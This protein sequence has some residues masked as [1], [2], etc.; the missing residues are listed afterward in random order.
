MLDLTETAR[1]IV[2]DITTSPDAPARAGLRISAEPGEGVFAVT[3]ADEPDP[4]DLVVRRDGATVYLD[5]ATAAAL[6]HK[7]L[8]TVVDDDGQIGFDLSEQR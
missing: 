6:D 1:V 2:R 5:P 8:D 4:T 3:A 7:V